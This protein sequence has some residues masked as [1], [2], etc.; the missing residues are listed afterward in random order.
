[1]KRHDLGL[2]EFLTKNKIVANVVK[3]K[4]KDGE[5]SLRVQASSKMKKIINRSPGLKAML[6]SNN[7]SG[8]LI[9]T[10]LMSMKAS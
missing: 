8:E 4:N 10:D 9:S 7:T 3:I 1:M 5:D 6:I 2:K